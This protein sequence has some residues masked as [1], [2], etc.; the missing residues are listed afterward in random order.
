[1]LAPRAHS[2]SLLSSSTALCR[3]GSALVLMDGRDGSICSA[4][5]A[6]GTSFLVLQ[7]DFGASA[8]FPATQA[9]QHSVTE[10]AGS[11]AVVSR[12]NSV[13][14][15][16]GVLPDS[17]GPGLAGLPL[18]AASYASFTLASPQRSFTVTAVAL[19]GSARSAPEGP[20][21]SLAVA[22]ALLGATT[23]SWTAAGARGGAVSSRELAR[24]LYV[25][26]QQAALE[27]LRR[28]FG[29]QY[30][31]ASEDEDDEDAQP[32]RQE[33]QRP[34]AGRGAAGAGLT[35][36]TRSRSGSRRAAGEGSSSLGKGLSRSVSRL[37]QRLHSMLRRKQSSLE[38]LPSNCCCSGPQTPP[39]A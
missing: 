11:L 21:S 36:R 39:N 6:A 7:G 33:Q 10:L 1:M 16:L 15:P 28:R 14:R 20:D 31:E 18:A 8:S 37:S 29:A 38:R 23:G 13:S 25:H 4:A 26:Q 12:A 32:R 9:S 3:L 24:A 34:E 22:A 27:E 35:V 19:A 17:A 5:P 2:A 30:Q